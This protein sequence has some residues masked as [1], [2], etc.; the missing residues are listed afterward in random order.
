M[1]EKKENNKKAI[2]SKGKD[3]WGT[4]DNVYSYL[5]E[6]FGKFDF[7]PC[8][9]LNDVNKWNGLEA[10]WKKNNFVNPPYSKTKEWI[11]KGIIEMEK[12]KR[13][14]FLIAS[15]TDTKVWHEKIFEKASEIYFIK[16]RISFV[17]GNSGAPFPSAI[18]VFDKK[19][20]EKKIGRM[21]FPK[22][23]R[24]GKLFYG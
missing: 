18:I 16:G 2:Y 4:P 7:D 6:V 22:R 21:E 20:K 15:R 8:P 9:M 24:G 11:E 17:G 12:G 23:N 10:E 13:S 1:K 14:V 3:D 5:V 19:I